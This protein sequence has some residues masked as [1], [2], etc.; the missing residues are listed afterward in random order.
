[1]TSVFA[2]LMGIGTHIN[3]TLTARTRARELQAVLDVV[4]E[5]DGDFNRG[6]KFATCQGVIRLDNVS[7]AYP[8]RPDYQ[9]T[10]RVTGL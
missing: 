10:N 1:M 4:P 6:D 2:T 8:S 3:G 7:F 5:I 9:V